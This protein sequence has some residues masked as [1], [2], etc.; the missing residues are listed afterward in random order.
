[1]KSRHSD[2]PVKLALLAVLGSLIASMLFIGSWIGPH[3][4]HPLGQRILIAVIL[5]ASGFTL[6]LRSVSNLKNGFENQRW[7]ASQM[8]PLRKHMGG[9]ERVEPRK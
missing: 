7:P 5:F 9:M 4:G 1:M 3:S 2:S 8:E 6:L